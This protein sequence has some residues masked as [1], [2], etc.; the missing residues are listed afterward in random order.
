[1]RRRKIARR[2]GLAKAL[3]ISANRSSSSKTNID[4]SK[5]LHTSPLVSSS[6]SANERILRVT[7]AGFFS[8]YKSTVH[9]GR[10]SATGTAI[11]QIPIIL[12]AAIEA[13]KA[14]EE[15][16]RTAVWLEP[17]DPMRIPFRHSS[18]SYSESLSDTSIQPLTSYGLGM[19]I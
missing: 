14:L 17:P 3:N 10:E 16:A 5:C 7:Q 12:D 9:R 19:P 4:M 2:W 1:M 6:S 18:T 11:E 8:R 15:R 13:K